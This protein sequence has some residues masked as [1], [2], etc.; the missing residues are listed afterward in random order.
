MVFEAIYQLDLR[1]PY[2]TVFFL[3]L[4]GEVAIVSVIFWKEEFRTPD[5]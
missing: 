2:K 1:F 3:F 5:T 4:F